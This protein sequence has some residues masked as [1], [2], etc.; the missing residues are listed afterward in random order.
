MVDELD[1]VF[2]RV[3]K[4]SAQRWEARRQ[5]QPGTSTSATV[6]R[7][8][9]L[10]ALAPPADVLALGTV[11][12]GL[13]L[14]GTVGTGKSMLMDLLYAELST[15][16]PSAS[17][18][19]SPSA[20]AGLDVADV[21]SGFAIPCRRVHFHSFMLEVHSRIHAWKQEYIA[22]HGRSKNLDMRPE[23]DAVVQVAKCISAEAWLLCF[24]EFQVTDVAD[25]MILQ[26]L[27]STLFRDGVAVV[28]TSNRPPSDLYKDGLNREHFLPFIASLEAHCKVLEM[29]SRIDY[30]RQ[31]SAAVMAASESSSEAQQM[32][33]DKFVHPLNAANRS[34]M[35]ESI[36]RVTGY[37]GDIESMPVST[38]DVMMGRTL[39]IRSPSPRVAV[40]SFAELCSRP[41]GA[42]DYLALCQHFDTVFLLD[43]P[44]LTRLRHNDARRFITLVDEL[45]EHRIQVYVSSS[46]PLDNLFDPLLRSQSASQ[47]QSKL[48][49]DRGLAASPGRPELDGSIE[50]A[51]TSYSDSANASAITN[52]QPLAATPRHARY[53]RGD[54]SLTSVTIGPTATTGSDTEAGGADPAGEGEEVEDI[55]EELEEPEEQLL[56]NFSGA[57]S[58]HT[59]PDAAPTST[60]ST[61]S[62][63]PQYTKGAVSIVTSA[64]ERASMS[65]LTFACQ[66]A[67]S[68]LVEMTAGM[69]TRN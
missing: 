34:K 22:K 50:D 55:E 6:G 26:R 60:A 43:V 2:R 15:S 1:K 23:R 52:A 19:N 68:R 47:L 64:A 3:V 13:Y 24:D 39:E 53:S 61:A 33:N 21:S 27:F 49:K 14:Y 51:G 44:R 12:R 57:A 28:A 42:A 25:A 35:V 63:Q 65:E 54:D 5:L 32:V 7:S 58:A 16:A 37:L 10:T 48:N 29:G 45:Y 20:A 11:P 66:R 9:N 8:D 36:R 4:Y 46:S 59:T 41:V 38:V 40:A 69:R 31:R 62:S 18:S 56:G 30:R 17:R 67:V